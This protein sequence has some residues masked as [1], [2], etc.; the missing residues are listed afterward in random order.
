MD[1]LHGRTSVEALNVV[2]VFPLHR[3]GKKFKIV[4][5]F[6]HTQVVHIFSQFYC[7]N[8]IPAL[9]VVLVHQ[10]YLSCIFSILFYTFVSASNIIFTVRFLYKTS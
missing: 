9:E 7:L 6:P 8:F 2:Q 5:L 4:H 1:R 10:Y 3:A